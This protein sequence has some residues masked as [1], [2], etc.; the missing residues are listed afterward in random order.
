MCSISHSNKTR[1]I[2]LSVIIIT[3]N[4]SLFVTIYYKWKHVSTFNV[5][6]HLFQFILFHTLLSSKFLQ[7]LLKDWREGLLQ[8]S[9]F[10][11][12]IL[13]GPLHRKLFLY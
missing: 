11:V 3:L 1:M 8:V 10:N 12:N 5:D 9:A 7:T 4:T 13:L 6:V 2:S